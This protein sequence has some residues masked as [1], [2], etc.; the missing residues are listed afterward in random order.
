M[1]KKSSNMR[2]KELY[3]IT[4]IDNLRSIL[5]RG[6]LS[7]RLIEERGV[8]FKA[9]Y[10]ANIVSNRKSKTTPNGRS[11][12]DF[13][14]V[15][16][17]PRNPMLFRV[18]H[19][20][21]PDEIV[22]L[23]LSPSVLEIP[24]AY[25]TNGNAANN[26]TDFFDYA[27]GIQAVSAIWDTISSEWWNSMDGSKRKIMA[28]GLIPESI[29][30]QL[31]H[32]IYVASHSVANNIRAHISAEQYSVIPEPTFF[33]FPAHRYKITSNLT[34]ADGDMFFSQMQTLTVSVNT[35]GIMGKGLA[36]RAKYQFPDVYVVYQDAC[37]K[38]WL[39]MGKPYL[40][41]REASFDDELFDQ[42]GNITT[43]NGVK[44]FLLF[45]TK[46]HWR[47]NS[48]LK[49]IEAGLS[50]LAINY[51]TEGIESIALPAL[52][53]GLGN[54]DW[55]EVGPIMCQYL[56]PLEIPVIIYLPREREIPKE[57]L[58]REYLLSKQ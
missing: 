3:Y 50:W 12:W 16:F 48:D 33:F 11:L 46:H 24:G 6:I 56:S 52:G 34:L 26:A 27:N 23:G 2:I 53:C 40:Y 44:W 29:P 1:A 51:K 42:P 25:I 4:H 14:N 30:P 9:I 47:E 37:R 13:A 20:T 31:I 58:T 45:P 18:V 19:E 8:T 54:L 10:D 38:K 35:V 7:H 22:V 32:S 55:Q 49:G 41:K 5:A 57:F 28:E 21:S 15:Y 17:Q 39:A 36:S 43:P